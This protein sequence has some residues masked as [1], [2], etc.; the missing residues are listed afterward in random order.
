M[1]VSIGGS[2]YVAG[3]IG[4]AVRASKR[5]TQGST[6]VSVPTGSELRRIGRTI[7]SVPT[8]LP[9]RPSSAQL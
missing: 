1:N 8:P 4:P 3:P 5:I 6:S 7:T 9:E 2:A